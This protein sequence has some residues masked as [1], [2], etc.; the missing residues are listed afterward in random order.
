MRVRYATTCQA[1]VSSDAEPKGYIFLVHMREI[2]LCNLQEGGQQN[3]SPL[4]VRAVN[5]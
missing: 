4:E 3:T 1:I 2:E 5:D